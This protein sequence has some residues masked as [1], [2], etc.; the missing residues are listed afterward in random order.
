MGMTFAAAVFIGCSAGLL[1]ALFGN[2]VLLPM[3]LKQQELHMSETYRFPLL[4][5]NRTKIAAGTIIVYRYVTPVIFC[6]VGSVFAV[7]LFG[8]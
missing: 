7:K 6:T 4:G 8:V 3:V 5:W 1:V 2:L